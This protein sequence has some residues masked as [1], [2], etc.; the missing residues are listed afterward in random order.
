HWCE[1]DNNLQRYGWLEHDGESFGVQEIVDG[2]L[3]LK[4][5]FVKQE[6]NDLGGQWTWRIDSQTLP[7]SN[8]SLYS[9]VVYFVVPSEG[10]SLSPV[11]DVSKGRSNH[12]IGMV[13]E[14][15]EL[16]KFNVEI[17]YPKK[18]FASN[19]LV[20]KATDVSVMSE[21]IISSTGVMK[22]KSEHHDHYLGLVAPT[23]EDGSTVIKPNVIAV[24]LT[25]TGGTSFEIIYRISLPDK[26]PNL[27]GPAFDAELKAHR[28]RF[29]DKFES[30]FHLQQKQYPTMYVDVAKYALSNMLGS[31]S[32]FHGHMAVQSTF[33][34]KP[35][36]Y[37]PLT[38]FSG[39]PSRSFFPRG[40]L[41]DEGFHQLLLRHWD[42]N[43]SLSIVASWLDLMNVEGWIPREV[44]LGSEAVRKVPQEFIIQHNNVANPPMFFY[45]IDV[46]TTDK[47]FVE[48]NRPLLQRIYPKLKM[49]F[50]WLNTTQA[51][52][53]PGTYRFE[54]IFS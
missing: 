9:F 50:R 28:K 30:L 38:L 13:G 25:V 42:A 53:R 19:Y 16:G 46:M 54:T 4:T 44:I 23:S 49:W 33:T 14:T 29:E 51:G 10:S 11:F 21:L 17:S 40:F 48:A 24:Q 2:G 32:Y 37:G 22:V 43:L 47:T 15:K 45:L 18:I 12:V 7:A 3:K 35:V 27:S 1:D 39:V 26:N 52:K 34:K 6:S 5:T 20:S 8:T 31:I 36:P 41:W